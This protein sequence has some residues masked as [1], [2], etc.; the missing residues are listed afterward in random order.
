MRQGQKILHKLIKN[1]D[2]FG[3]NFRPG[4]AEKLNVDESKVFSNIHNYGN[5]TAASVGIALSE[6]LE[7]KKIKDNDIVVLA[8][9]G[10]GFYWCSIVIRW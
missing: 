4:V 7:Q 1:A 2:I 6:A 5:T 10:S 9:F 3:Q 8:A